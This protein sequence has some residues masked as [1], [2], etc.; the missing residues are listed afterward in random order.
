MMARDIA[1]TAEVIDNLRQS[2]RTN[3]AHGV[4]IEFHKRGKDSVPS[5]GWKLFF[6]NLFLL[7]P[8]IFPRNNST[9]LDIE[10]LR[11][12]MHGGTLYSLE[13][14]ESFKEIQPD[15]TRVFELDSSFWSVAR[16]DFMPYWYFVS[17]KEGTTPR[18]AEYTEDMSLRF[19]KPFKDVRQWKRHIYDRYNP[20]T[21]QER[22]RRLQ[23]NDTGR[24]EIPIIPTPLYINIKP[25]GSTIIV[26]PTWKIYYDDRSKLTADYLAGM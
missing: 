7:F 10:K 9:V 24:T 11:I 25:S 20:F 21:P 15:E 23:V 22:M 13:P 3:F 26:G 1:I 6:H 18:I 2:S 14:V 8:S 5:S 17:T 4:R 16:T 12:T 19:V